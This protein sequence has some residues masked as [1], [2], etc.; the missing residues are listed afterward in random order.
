L[1]SLDP[2][3]FFFLSRQK[4]VFPIAA[5][6]SLL[7]FSSEP[8]WMFD[9]STPPSLSEGR[10]RLVSLGFHAQDY[11]WRRKRKRSLLFFF[12]FS[13]SC[14]A[15]LFFGGGA[16]APTLPPRLKREWKAGFFRQKSGKIELLLFL[17][18]FSCA[19]RRRGSE[20][21]GAR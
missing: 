15:W 11:P 2:A 5:S 8:T 17:F 3:L 12:F 21:C 9:F 19:S 14:A 6:S 13:L 10:R 1:G 7:F 4:K 20:M 18:L 16:R